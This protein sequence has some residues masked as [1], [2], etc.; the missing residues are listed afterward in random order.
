MLQEVATR[1]TVGAENRARQEAAPANRRC[2]A[3]PDGIVMEDE[4]EV[5]ED[6][7]DVMKSSLDIGMSPSLLISSSTSTRECSS[8]YQT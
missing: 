7:S 4:D 5:F 2:Q 8:S 1:D 3:L 6:I